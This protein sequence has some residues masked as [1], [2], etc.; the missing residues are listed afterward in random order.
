MSRPYGFSRGR[1]REI[2]LAIEG[3]ERELL[4]SLA[5][6]LVAFVGSDPVD[7]DAD[8]LA[9]MVGID[10]TA[11]TPDDPALARLLPD[12]FLDDAESAA[13]FRRFTERDLRATKVSHARLV[14]E[15]LDARL[16]VLPDDHIAAWLGFLNDSRLALGTRIDITEE[17]HDEL[18]SLPDGDPRAAMFHVYD[19]LTYLQDSLVHLLLP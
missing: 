8:P 19:W 18:A 4:R 15:D 14:V 6:Q 13:E 3:V 7:E 5:Q 12:A 17:N 16:E 2:R 9:T 11:Q 10:A 1:K